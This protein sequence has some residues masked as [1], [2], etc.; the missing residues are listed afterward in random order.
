MSKDLGFTPAPW[1]IV[2]HG[3][4]EQAAQVFAGPLEVAYLGP[5]FTADDREHKQIM[6]DAR[7]IAAA[8][9]LYAACKE[10]FRILDDERT[11]AAVPL[12]TLRESANLLRAAIAK[13]TGK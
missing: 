7:L 12:A 11:T 3:K 4:K 10:A 5:I 2:D 9:E 13:A 1:T 8:P 6:A